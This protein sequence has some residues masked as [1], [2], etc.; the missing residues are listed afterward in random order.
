MAEAVG[1]LVNDTSENSMAD[2][3]NLNIEE[4]IFVEKHYL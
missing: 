2:S 3:L 4:V 1:M